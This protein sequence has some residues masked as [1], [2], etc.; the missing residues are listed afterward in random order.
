MTDFS[1]WVSISA[2]AITL[3]A[4]WVR[5]NML[6]A[7]L[8][9]RS[10]GDKFHCDHQLTVIRSEVAAVETRSNAGLQSFRDQLNRIDCKVDRLLE[11]HT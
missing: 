11:R 2:V 4:G 7:K 6:I 5:L 10:L 3:I 9:T 8:E 1:L